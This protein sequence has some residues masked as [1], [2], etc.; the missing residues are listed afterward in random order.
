MGTMSSKEFVMRAWGEFASRDPKRVGAV[1]TADAEWLAPADNATARAVGGTHHMIG[2]DRIVQFLTSEF[3]TVF[4][5]EVSVDFRG[6]FADGDTVVV[7]ERM[8]AT[9]A[10]GGHYD[11]D[12]YFVFELEGRLIKRVRE[13]MDTQRGAAWFATPP[14]PSRRPIQQTRR[15]DAEQTASRCP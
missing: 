8:Q 1:F 10:H 2:R 12:Y 14:P 9:L 5:A 7:E 11:N 15:G 6:V 3:G 4:V 13:Y